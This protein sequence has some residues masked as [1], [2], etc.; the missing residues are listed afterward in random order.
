[1]HSTCF[2]EQELRAFQL[3]QLAD[4]T[5]EAVAH[6]LAEMRRTSVVRSQNGAAELGK[7]AQA[8]RKIT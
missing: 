2:S 4:E 7:F 5:L 8:F 1:M 6:H 3:G